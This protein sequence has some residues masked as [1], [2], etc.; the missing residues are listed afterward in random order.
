M[1][2][3]RPTHVVEGAA[4]GLLNYAQPSWGQPE[5]RRKPTLSVISGAQ[6]LNI[7]TKTFVSANALIYRLSDGRLG[8]RMGKQAVLLLHTVGRSSG[9]PYVTP[10]S[11]YRDGTNYLL[12]ASNWGEKDQPD[13]FRNLMQ[14]PQTTIQIKDQKISVKARQMAGKEYDRLWDHVTKQNPQYLTYQKQLQRR[15]PIIVL[16]PVPAAK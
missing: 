15:I 16:T 13:W 5:Y 3:W 11:F 12:V 10:L 8:S 9:K 4:T 6:L 1:F 2:I 14:K 7:W